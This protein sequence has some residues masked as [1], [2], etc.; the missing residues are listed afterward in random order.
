[1]KKYQKILMTLPL[2]FALAACN[3]DT[4]KN[5][6]KTD[7]NQEVVDKEK[8]KEVV[9]KVDLKEKL[10]SLM[11]D[12]SYVSQFDLSD[13]SMKEP[14]GDKGTEQFSAIPNETGDSYL[15]FYYDVGSIGD[16][17]LLTLTSGDETVWVSNVTEEQIAAFEKLAKTNTTT[18]QA[19]IQGYY[20]ENGEFVLG[21][22]KQKGEFLLGMHKVESKSVIPEGEKTN[23]AEG[24]VS[25]DNMRLST[26]TGVTITVK[27]KD[28]K[29]ETI[30]PILVG[31]KTVEEIFYVEDK[32]SVFKVVYFEV[33]GK[34]YFMFGDKDNFDK[35]IVAK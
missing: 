17:P 28:D 9:Q 3:D 8:T 23:I 1:M 19:A 2:L 13:R 4:A 10:D 6:K 29:T 21:T 27:L 31:E 5:D 16:D 33:D 24:V 7:T 11:K 30:Y 18:L 20:D 22:P 12:E 35:L 14:G 32:H 15:W 26:E 34:G 25:I